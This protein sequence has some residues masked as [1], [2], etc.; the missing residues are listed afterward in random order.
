MLQETLVLK[1]DDLTRLNRDNERL[2][3]ESRQQVKLLH[4]HEAHIQTLTGEIQGLKLAEAKSAGVAEQLQEQIATLRQNAAALNEA[5]AKSG[6][7]ELEA[8]LQLVAAQS[9]NEQLQRLQATEA[10]TLKAIR[11]PLLHLHQRSQRQPPQERRGS[12]QEQS[13]AQ[14]NGP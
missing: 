5:A 3:G 8:R 12:D 9:E 6:E 14:T 11:I 4:G 1:P 7:R 13:H 2:L 10:E